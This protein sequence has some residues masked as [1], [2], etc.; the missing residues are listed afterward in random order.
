[1]TTTTPVPRN[2]EAGDVFWVEFDPVVGSE[3]AGRRPALVL[4]SEALHRVSSRT[5]ICPITSNVEPWPTKVQIPSGC[6]VSGAVLADQARMVDHQRRHFRF[7]GRLP[8]DITVRVRE[9]VV[10]FMG[11]I[12]M[13]DAP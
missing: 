4:S 11:M 9:R 10:A 2:P 5:L 6:V 3:Q 7:I 13:R 8:D 1:M 12:A